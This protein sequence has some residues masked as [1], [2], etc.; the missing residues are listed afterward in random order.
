MCSLRIGNVGTLLYAAGDYDHAFGQEDARH[1][2][3]RVC[4]EDCEHRGGGHKFGCYDEQHML[5]F[6]QQYGH[7]HSFSVWQER[8]GNIC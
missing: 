6:Q 7:R 3:D 5:W 8:I 2:C 4:D 1:H